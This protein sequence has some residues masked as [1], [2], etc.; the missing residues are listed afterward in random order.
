LYQKTGG[1]AKAAG[2][3]FW[4]TQGSREKGADKRAANSDE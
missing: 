2:G 3:I 1:S 4:R